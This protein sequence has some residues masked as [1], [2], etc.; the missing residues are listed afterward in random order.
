MP[1][2][3]P[4]WKCRLC[5]K[6]YCGENTVDDV[7]IDEE[8]CTTFHNCED[9]R[10]G[11]AVLDGYTAPIKAIEITKENYSLRLITGCNEEIE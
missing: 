5:G 4:I 2:R 11:I 10:K 8:L 6:V 9:G 1:L 3:R 7:L